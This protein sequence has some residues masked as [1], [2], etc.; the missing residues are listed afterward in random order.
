MR[1]L[2]RTLAAR[3]TRYQARRILRAMERASPSPFATVPAEGYQRGI[4]FYSRQELI[5]TLQN[6]LAT[7]RTA[8]GRFPNLVSPQLYSEKVNHAKFFAPIKV[9]ASGNKLLTAHFLPPAL[10]GRVSLPEVVWHDQ[11]PA[12]PANESLAPGDYYLKA[13]HGSGMVKKVSFPLD[14]MQRKVLEAT[15]Q[16]WLSRPYGLEQ[17]EWW[18]NAFPPH[19][20]LERS[21]SART[22]S[23]SLLFYVLGGDVALI[24]VFAKALSPGVPNRRLLLDGSFQAHAEQ[25]PEEMRLGDLDLSEPLKQ[26]CLEVARTLG[27]QFRSVRIDLMVGDDERIY[28]NEV[29]FS[30]NAGLP[31]VGRELDR[32][33]GSLWQGAG[34]WR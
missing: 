10:E 13:S 25:D 15:C 23:I 24:T 28:L 30:P 11:Q 18:Y 16:Q 34:L 27:A 29:T 6:V 9:P 2:K 21:V 7:Y 20:L 14:A 17:G 12:L 33:L 5:A 4:D 31:F 8:C 1:T 3:I 32:R 22:P 26:R 19:L